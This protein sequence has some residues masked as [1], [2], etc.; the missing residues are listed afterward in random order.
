M[1]PIIRFEPAKLSYYPQSINIGNLVKR[2][3]YVDHTKIHLP[4]GQSRV[5]GPIIDYPKSNSLPI[6]YYFASQIDLGKFSKH[7]PFNL[8]PKEGFLYFFVKEY[9]DKGLVLYFDVTVSEL[10]RR[11][12]EHDQWFF[13]GCA[14]EKVSLDNESFDSRF[15][16]EKGKKEWDYFAGTEKSK[17]FGIYTHCQKSENEIKTIYHSSKV[18]LLQIGED[19]NDE[20]VFSVLI[21]KSDLV[22]K[23]FDNCTFEWGQS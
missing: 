10:E 11:I 5:G 23:K 14:V 4:I 2:K 9:C 12:V 7:D 17:I 21:E 8:L 3:N 15:R 13:D 6:D 22:K 20:G 1:I 16:N 19:F 18:L